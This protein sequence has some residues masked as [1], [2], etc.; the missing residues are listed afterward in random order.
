MKKNERSL[1]FLIGE[2]LEAVTF[3]MD[4]MQLQFREGILSVFSKMKL[5]HGD[6]EAGFDDDLFPAR[7]RRLISQHVAS[8]R[9]GDDEILLTFQ[10]GSIL[11]CDL[12]SELQKGR[13]AATFHPCTDELGRSTLVW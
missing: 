2:P 8:T 5:R 3:I 9:S 7:M 4:Y 6:F 1:E 12:S 11:S 10:D 13:E